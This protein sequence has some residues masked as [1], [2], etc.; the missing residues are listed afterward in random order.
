MNCGIYKIENLLDSKIYV[1]SSVNV[2][3]RKYKHFW[4]L[5]KGIHDNIHLQNAYNK[6]GEDNF[7]FSIIELCVVNDLILLENKYIN[8]YKS[9]D[10]N[11]GYNLAKVNEF[12]RNTFNDEVKLKLSKHNQNKNGNINRFKLTEMS[13][14][15]SQVFDNLFEAARYLIKEGFT[16]GSERNVRQK[17]ST[18]LRGKTINNGC[19]GSIRKT[20]YKHNFE[21]IN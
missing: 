14:G 3:N 6:F 15:G 7:T 13:G 8:S 20:I 11:F 21:L 17:L 5:R 10:S 12:R 16:K 9:S 19:N 1:G 4:M 2:N 18:T